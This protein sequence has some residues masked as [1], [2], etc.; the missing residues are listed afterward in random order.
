[1]GERG[2][3]QFGA[4][5]QGKARLESSRDTDEIANRCGEE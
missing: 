1:M 4:V 3:A 2:Y 5:R